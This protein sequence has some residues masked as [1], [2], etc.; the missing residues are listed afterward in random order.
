MGRGSRAAVMAIGAVGLVAGGA[1]VAAGIDALR[2]D[3]TDG[4]ALLRAGTP[5][6]LTEID[7]ETMRLAL[8]TEPVVT[9]PV[10]RCF[11]MPSAAALQGDTATVN[12]VKN[13]GFREA[14]DPLVGDNDG[15]TSHQLR[16]GDAAAWVSLIPRAMNKSYDF[17]TRHDSAGVRYLEVG[18]QP[19][20][21]MKKSIEF[22]EKIS[23]KA[24]GEGR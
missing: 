12:W 6:G 11:T 20:S 18:G 17:T 3:S 8:R 22:Y 1:G 7:C 21:E 24:Q 13:R 16:R 5:L 10:H 19:W 15:G 2:D 9:A 23:T 4:Y 14:A